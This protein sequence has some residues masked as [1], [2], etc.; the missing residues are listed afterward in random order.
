MP[1]F[2]L[3]LTPL[4]LHHKVVSMIDGERMTLWENF[5][6]TY[7]VEADAKPLFDELPTGTVAT[8]SVG[9]RSLL[10][11]SNQVEELIR[12]VCTTLE[13]DWS[14]GSNEYDGMLYIMLTKETGRVVPLY[15]GKAE[16]LGK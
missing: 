2:H 6:Q 8:K 10:R 15:I 13:D 16:T 14:K 4:L 5:N 11:R 3:C 12:A 7:G 9:N 1:R